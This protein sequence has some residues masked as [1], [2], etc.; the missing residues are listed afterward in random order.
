MKTKTKT[1]TAVSPIVPPA[2][3]AETTASVIAPP[4]AAIPAAPAPPIFTIEEAIRAARELINGRLA[5][6]CAAEG[7]PPL[8]SNSTPVVAAA[9]TFE[10]H[11][12]RAVDRMGELGID[13][14]E[15]NREVV[16]GARIMICRAVLT[17]YALG[18]KSLLA[19]IC[20]DGAE[21]DN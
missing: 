17:N 6:E 14:A 19:K 21:I 10:R 2:P 5:A 3:L 15:F 4:A 12:D 13:A 16:I 18:E 7:V 20:C 1:K 9:M 11:Y 8:A